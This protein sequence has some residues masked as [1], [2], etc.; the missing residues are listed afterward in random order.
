M[1]RRIAANVAKLPEL[2]LRKKTGGPP[3]S[4]PSWP[5]VADGRLDLL[6]F[7]GIALHAKLSS[8]LLTSLLA[9]GAPCAVVSAPKHQCFTA[10]NQRLFE[11]ACDETA[12]G[13]A[14][15]MCAFGT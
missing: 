5:F 13:A 10:G 6:L 12:L 15:A 4:A 2:L 1:A 11:A 3:S 8:P 9:S 14:M 7:C